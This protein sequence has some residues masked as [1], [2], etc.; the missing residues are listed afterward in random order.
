M[1]NISLVRG[2]QDPNSNRAKQFARL[3]RGFVLQMFLREGEFW[4]AV[5]ETREQYGIES[6]VQMP[7]AGRAPLYTV[8]TQDDLGWSRIGQKV[9]EAVLDG[10]PKLGVRMI[11]EGFEDASL[12]ITEWG[13]FL[14]ACVLFDPP[15]DKLVEF[16]EYAGPSWVSVEPVDD[17]KPQRIPAASPIRIVRDPM[18]EKIQMM[19]F[20]MKTI[21][22]LEK[23]FPDIDIW[24][25][26]QEIWSKE[27]L[28]DQYHSRLEAIPER[29]YID[30]REDTHLRDVG[31]AYR[32]LKD[33]QK[34]RNDKGGA[35]ARDPLV[36]V[37]CAVLYDRHNS[38]DPTDKRRREWTYKRLA[39]HFGLKSERAAKQFVELGRE[40]LE[41]N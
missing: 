24:D 36:A 1:R 8:F 9:R 30:V 22:E 26:V 37:Q 32:L 33:I 28:I 21:Q 31:D 12:L 4:N 19:G 17:E 6:Q 14:T 18:G 2:R 41:K 11:P 16:A 27:G 5:R 35:P 23:T 25:Q 39:K 34:G 38:T 29:F 10:V 15:A 13:D 7:P 40:F 3:K 20:F